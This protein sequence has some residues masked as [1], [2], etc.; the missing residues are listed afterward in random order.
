MALMDKVET[1]VK[2]DLEETEAREM[3]LEDKEEL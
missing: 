2:M 1:E 3:P